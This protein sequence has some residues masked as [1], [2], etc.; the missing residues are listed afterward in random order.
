MSTLPQSLDD[1]IAQAR[2]ATQAALD[3]GLTRLQVELAFSELKIMLLAEQFVQEFESLGPAFRVFFSDP[4]SAALARRDWGEKPFPIRGIGELKAEIQPEEQL[5]LF[6]EP[7]SVE[8]NQVEALC[9]QAGERPVVFLNPKLEDVA[10]LGIG[11]AGRQLRD[12]F[13]NTL[14][15]CYH[16]RPLQGGAVYRCYPGL[17]Q[18]WM[19]QDGDYKLVAEQAQRPNGEQIEAIFLKA[20]GQ[21]PPEAAVVA[22]RRGFFSNLKGFLRALNQ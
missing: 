8:V 9:N 7:S 4:G 1:A 19:E 21:A 2:K 3:D 17:W 10:T 12:R 11:Y 6:I 15:S 22:P 20:S 13:L 16:L 14:E 18:V 5:F